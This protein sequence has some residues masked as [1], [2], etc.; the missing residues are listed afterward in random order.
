[1]L[2]GHKSSAFGVRDDGMLMAISF[3]DR[4]TRTSKN[5]R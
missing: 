4:R 5:A 2:I 3:F 1:M